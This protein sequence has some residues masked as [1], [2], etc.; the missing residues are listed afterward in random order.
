MKLFFSQ[1]NK[2][3]V[4]LCDLPRASKT[5]LVILLNLSLAFILIY[6]Y[7]LLGL[8]LTGY[9]ASSSLLKLG[10][11]DIREIEI[12]DPNFENYEL[13]LIRYQPLS[14]V[15]DSKDKTRNKEQKS[16]S[17]LFG[18]WSQRDK[19][20]YFW[21]LKIR[22]LRDKTKDQNYE[23]DSERIQ[24]FFQALKNTRRYYSIQRSKEKEKKAGFLKDDEGKYITFHLNFILASRENAK[25]S[26]KNQKKKETLY[27]GKS[28]QSGRE[29]YVFRKGEKKIYLSRSFLRK[30]TGEGDIHYFRDRKILPKAIQEDLI[31]SI[32]VLSPTGSVI[33]Q[34][35]KN[36]ENWQLQY[37]SRGEK[38]L[39]QDWI[40]SFLSDLM[41]WKASA[42][43]KE[44]PKG[45]NRLY[46]CRIVIGYKT[47][48][49]KDTQEQ[50]FSIDVLGRMEYSE[51]ILSMSDDTLRT[52]SSSFIEALLEPQK[53]LLA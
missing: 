20:Q 19:T 38:K 1:L 51:Y 7:N 8:K 48:K 5:M 37:P 12:Y 47:N 45:L 10:Q 9:E 44:K 13:R 14:D 4:L 16:P 53:S 11:N 36:K 27:E 24:E 2:K 28:I 6:Q 41:D 26:S 32:S 31:T 29:A 49:D 23:A 40:Q 46:S 39:R 18:S 22:D 52:F 3:L 17:K 33:T 50:K 43:P 21:R 35:I 30:K 15:S 34:L 42:F 25:K